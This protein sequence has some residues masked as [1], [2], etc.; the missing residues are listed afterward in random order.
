MQSDNGLSRREELLAVA[1]KLFATRGYHG[2]RMDDVA[3][4]VGLNKATVYHYYASKSLILFDIYQRAAESTLAAVHVDPSWSAREGLYQYT[5]RLLTQIAANPEGAAVYFQEQ[6]YIQE[7]LTP[8]QVDEVRAKEVQVYEHLHGLIDRGIASG[9]FFDCDSHVV[10]LGY[11]GMTMGAYRWLRP[12]GR[13][14]AVEIAQEFSTAVLRGLIRDES[15]RTGSPL[16]D[17][18]G[19]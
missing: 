12:S 4:V 11:L 5:V 6:P 8:E 1:T 19:A 2:T 10:A 13:R 18:A 17:A 3:D 9:E 15:I 16:G 14:S 7:W